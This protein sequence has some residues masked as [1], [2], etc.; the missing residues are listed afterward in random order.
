[1]LSVCDT[2]VCLGFG[3]LVSIT[4]NSILNLRVTIIQMDAARRTR[5]LASL[6][7]G[8]PAGTVLGYIVS[9]HLTTFLGAPAAWG[10]AVG[11][12]FWTVVFLVT[13]AQRGLEIAYLEAIADGNLQVVAPVTASAVALVVHVL[14]RFLSLFG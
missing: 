10:F 11:L 1:M 3:F 7:V 2:L 5:A 12:N 6:F 13:V 4:Q 9:P 8:W 14:S